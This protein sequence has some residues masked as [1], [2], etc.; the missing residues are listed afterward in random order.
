[1]LWRFFSRARAEEKLNQSAR[2]LGLDFGGRPLRRT[3]MTSAER[4]KTLHSLAHALESKDPY[5]HG[6]STR[7]EHLSV[8]TAKALGLSEDEIT[9][10]RTAAL[11]HD[12]GKIR[13]PTRI[14]RKPSELTIEEKLIVQEHAGVGA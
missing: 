11:L 1:M 8:R 9:D 13:V 5:T 6:H 12:V 2:A 3:Q 10:L 4:L 14:L 7:V